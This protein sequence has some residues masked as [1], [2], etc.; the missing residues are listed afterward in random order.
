MGSSGIPA[1]PRFLHWSKDRKYEYAG[2][3][4]VWEN[5]SASKAAAEVGISRG[6]LGDW[7]NAGNR[8]RLEGEVSDR[9]NEDLSPGSESPSSGDRPSGGRDQAQPPPPLQVS[10]RL[11]GPDEFYEYYFGHWVCPDCEVH[12]PDPEF[13]REIR[14]AIREPDA[15]RVSILMPPYHS[16]STEVSVKDTIYDIVENPNSRTIIV[17]KSLD[18]AKTFLVSIKELLTNRDLYLPGRNL[19]DDWGPF[20]PNGQTGWS[21]TQLYVQGRTT[22]EK[23]PTVQVLGVGQQIYGRR[24]DKIKFDDVATL[25]NNRNP[26]RVAEMVEWTD[27]EVL[28]RIG[29]NGLF[30][31]VGTRVAPGDFHEVLA[32]RE[33]YTVLR[34]PAIIDEAEKIMLWG[35][36]FDY[37]DAALRRGEMS[38]RDWMMVYQQLSVGGVSQDFTPEA[39]ENAKDHR[40]GLGH[41]ESDWVLVAGLDLAGGT[42][43]S[44]YTAG[45]LIGIDLETQRRYLIDAFNRKSMR[46]SQLH[47]Q[48]LDWA[49]R[50]PLSEWRVEKNGLQSQIVQYNDT[51]VQEL[52]KSGVRVVP[53][54]TGGNKWDAEFG[55]ASMGPLF[56]TGLINIPWADQA[57]RS[58]FHP[59]VE[60]LLQ[61]PYGAVSDL[62]MALWFA[63]LASRDNVRRKRMPMFQD[64]RVP[65]RIGRRRRIY[66]RDSGQVTRV[67]QSSMQRAMLGNHGDGRPL[68]QP[69]ESDPRRIDPDSL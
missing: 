33:G 3:L 20:A 62:V 69:A 42:K 67:T 6:R 45:I 58:L 59:L 48:M 31:D 15:R 34:Y 2:R 16:K 23:D 43:D 46:P 14:R 19:I 11:P 52:A 39:L 8:D 53:H 68:V 18:M 64:R 54:H 32:K 30:V 41:Y 49:D 60:Q 55:V 26:H 40:R 44:G 61:F 24:A 28:S 9:G 57:A 12:H 22:H 36:H 37:N 25:E 35:D 13:H 10:R 56:S 63:D 1:D 50:Y 38:D 51:L 7:L 21:T 27:K 5:W 4:V 17:S 47:D 66:R 65:E 29:K